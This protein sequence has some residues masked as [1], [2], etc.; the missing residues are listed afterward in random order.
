MKKE[1]A[2]EE[3]IQGLEANINS[4]R[5]TE[6]IRACK[7]VLSVALDLLPKEKAQMKTAFQEGRISEYQSQKKLPFTFESFD[8]YF[9]ESYETIGSLSE[10][11]KVNENNLT[12]FGKNDFNYKK[13]EKFFNAA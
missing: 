4:S 9:R 2:F 10:M 8:E 13:M 6:W 1:T 3:L 5:N 7:M 11:I 12:I